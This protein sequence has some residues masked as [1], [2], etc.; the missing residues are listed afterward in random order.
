MTAK[1]ETH[2]NKKHLRLI[3]TVI[4][5]TAVLFATAP[6]A[7]ASSP[8]LR[9]GSSG[10]E[11][12][13][14][15]NQLIKLGYTD[16]T[17][18]TG[19]FG[20]ETRTAVIRFQSNNSLV[21]DGLAGNLTQTKLYS[22]AAKALLLREGN[23]GEAVQTLQLRLKALGYFPGTGTGY[24]GPV[25]KAAVIAF[26]K[27]TGLSADGIAG[28]KT[29]I[30]AFSS[31]TP[32]AG[33]STAAN[34][35]AAIADI[36]LA[37]LG[38]PYL[39]GGNGPSTFDCSGLAYYAM[40]QAGFSVPRWSSAAYSGRDGWVKITG[41]SGLQKGDLLF[42]LSENWTSINHMGIY[43]GDGQF[44]HASS[45]QG[46]VMVSS[47]SNSYWASHYTFARRVS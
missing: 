31:S 46:K 15:Q 25:T 38:T 13:K 19:N 30:Q 14:L 9:V 27:A 26:Q 39:L 18:A 8:T 12:T 33:S 7:L 41:T 35:A 45:G 21:A 4:C 23:S 1:G 36:A 22:S 17:S 42:F 47:L 44:V 2:L 16:F 10:S 5:I 20:A 28:P 34:P 3:I 43:T 24:F 37:Q 32:S 29:R 11:V 6:S 40:T